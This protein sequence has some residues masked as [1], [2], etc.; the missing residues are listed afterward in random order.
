MDA[1]MLGVEVEDEAPRKKYDLDKEEEV[2]VRHEV[3]KRTESIRKKKTY[4]V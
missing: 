4:P 2:M 3:R 1:E